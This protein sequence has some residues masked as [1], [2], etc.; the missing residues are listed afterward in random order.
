[1]ETPQNIRQMIVSRSEE[2]RDKKETRT[3]TQN[4]SLHLYFRQ[5]AEA[6][7]AAGL[8]IQ[9]VLDNFK[10][11]IEWSEESVK[12]ILWRTAQKRM[13]GK[14]STTA[15]LKQGEI[16]QIWEAMNRFLGEKL[17]IETIPFPSIEV[18]EQREFT[19]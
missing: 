1:M 2:L 15:L 13:L 14:K 7:N 4:A 16:D 11:E 3:L 12:E 6:L 8:T 18:L 10:M 5:V 19:R 17:H 9:E